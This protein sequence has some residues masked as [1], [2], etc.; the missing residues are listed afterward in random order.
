[1]DT[2]A[3]LHKNADIPRG[4]PFALFFMEVGI[5]SELLIPTLELISVGRARQV[6]PFAVCATADATRHMA[7]SLLVVRLNS[8]SLGIPREHHIIELA[9]CKTS[10]N[11]RQ[12]AKPME[13]SDLTP[14]EAIEKVL[15][16]GEN[17][18]FEELWCAVKGSVN[19]ATQDNQW[20][21]LMVACG[22]VVDAT[23]FIQKIIAAGADVTAV[24][25]DGWTA[26]HWSAYHDRPQAAQT[27]LESAPPHKHTELFEIMAADGR[28]AKEVAHAEDH[29]EV[30]HVIEKFVE[31]LETAA[32]EQVYAE[33][34]AI[35]SP[36]S[37]EEEDAQKLPSAG[38]EEEI[39]EET[40]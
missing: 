25:G 1:M 12:E 37:S 4:N 26:L 23:E 15:G 9:R 32:Q 18:D 24:D 11:T 27:L 28:T 35:N 16:A 17:A 13:Y 21:A 36:Q 39:E 8:R 33:L 38:E 31:L 7:M 3:R 40:P 30:V 5:L 29:H 6:A 10:K 22:S 19:A 2:N 14:V 34:A 20:T